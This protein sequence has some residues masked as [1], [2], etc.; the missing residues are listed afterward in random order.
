MHGI[1]VKDAEIMGT[2]FY[3]KFIDKHN[4]KVHEETGKAPADKK[5]NTMDMIRDAQLLR[6]K[7]IKITD[8]KDVNKFM[9]G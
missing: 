7:G 8:A 4:A 1:N 2:D 6:E 9:G 5:D 3:I